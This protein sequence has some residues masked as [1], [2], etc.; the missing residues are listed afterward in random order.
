LA[1]IEEDFLVQIPRVLRLSQE[2]KQS[3]ANYSIGVSQDD[4]ESKRIAH[5]SSVLVQAYEF[6]L[7]SL[8]GFHVEAAA[9]HPSAYVDEFAKELYFEE[10]ETY[11]L[12]NLILDTDFTHS[13]LCLPDEPNLI[14]VA[15]CFKMK[16][17]NYRDKIRGRSSLLGMEF[18]S[19]WR[20]KIFHNFMVKV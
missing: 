7:L 20:V 14:L 5:A 18:S 16:E 3:Y 17:R 11:E 1:S 8:F 15:I 10:R 19:E 12:E 4:E 6:Q 13:S 2:I 9:S